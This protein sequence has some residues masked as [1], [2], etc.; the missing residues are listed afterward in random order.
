MPPAGRPADR[1]AEVAP[2]ASVAQPGSELSGKP[3][4]GKSFIEQLHRHRAALKHFF[5][6]LKVPGALFQGA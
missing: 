3:I 5:C 2:A 1:S 4:G 6:I